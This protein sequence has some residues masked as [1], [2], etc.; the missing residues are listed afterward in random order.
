MKTLE[1]I[2]R[3]RKEKLQLKAKEKREIENQKIKRKMDKKMVNM[4]MDHQSQNIESREK[5]QKM[6]RKQNRKIKSKRRSLKER[7][8][9]FTETHWI[10][11]R[12]RSL[13]PN[14]R[15]IIT[16]TGNV[17]LVRHLSPWIQ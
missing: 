8:I 2:K 14:G 13:S 10:S 12:R 3:P 1:K 7:R 5:R 6:K 16:E 11:K 17:D 4:P 9:S 15:S